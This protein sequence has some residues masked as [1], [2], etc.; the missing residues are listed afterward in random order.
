VSQLNPVSTI[1]RKRDGGEHTASEIRALVDGFVAGD[2]TDYQMSAWLMAAYLRGLSDRETVALTDAM[3]R[4]G[5]VLTLGR[6]AAPKVDKHSTGGV[7]DKISLCLAP[8]VA[9]AG[10][11]VPM[12]SGRGLG[13]T[14]GTLDKLESIPGYR[15]QLSHARFESVVARVGCSIV[16]QSG[17][18]A[19]ADGRMYALR[20]VTGT[21]ESI[22]LI[23]AS[24]LSKKLAAGL[25]GLVMDVKAGGGAF[26]RDLE[27]AKA[28]G[29]ALVRV[30]RGAGLRMSALVTR[31]D[32]PIGWAIGNA[33]EVREAIEVLKGG[34]PSDTVELTEALGAEMLHVAGVARSRSVARRRIRQ[35]LSD[36]TALDRF[37]AMI[38]AHG[39]S[40]GVVDDDDVLPRAPHRVVVRA[41][42]RGVVAGLDARALGLLAVDL[43]A[44]RQHV[45]DPVDPAVGIELRAR[46]GDAVSKGDALA[47][48]H[49][50]SRRGATRL[51]GRAAAA[52]T[53]RARADAEGSRIVERL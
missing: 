44:G 30:G 53:I 37:R 43:G 41:P 27:D 22:P 38:E 29:R 16:G 19:P 20:D 21:V 3:L 45:D 32:E 10:V 8:A 1:I 7:G 36:G 31:M 2:V 40:P 4:S 24:I 5:K 48:L 35:V 47:I 50:A 6:V 51:V 11:A 52:V 17:E 46:R 13:H 42:R 33:L 18:L 34:G 49:L 9:A 15:I 28:L 39:G 23:V 25:E 26:M 14:G 12:I